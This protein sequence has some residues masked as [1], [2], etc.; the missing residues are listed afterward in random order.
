MN[1]QGKQSGQNRGAKAKQN[2]FESMSWLYRDGLTYQG[3]LQNVKDATIRHNRSHTNRAAPQGSQTE[4][5]KTPKSADS[6]HQVKHSTQ[7]AEKPAVRTHSKTASKDKYEAMRWLYEDDESYNEAVAILKAEES[8]KQAKKQQAKDKRKQKL[9]AIKTSAVTQTTRVAQFAKTR[10]KKVAV[11]G[12]LSLVIVVGAGFVVLD[13]SGTSAPQVAGDAVKE[14]KAPEFSTVL[15]ASDSEQIDTPIAYD[16]L[17]KVASYTDTLDGKK[18]TVTQQQ[19]PDRFK[20]D[21]Q[22]ELEKFAKEM[23]ANQPIQA[24]DTRAFTGLSIRGPQTVVM[25]KNDLLVFMTAE[26]E[27]PAGAWVSYIESLQ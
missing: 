13:G 1:M 8:A 25:I 11:A 22:V 2:R 19:V 18:I 17:R 5:R 6:R 12:V 16:E 4:P 10:P 24:G 21:Q 23:N 20:V 27:V 26:S 3:A 9:R 15:P 14:Q 7:M